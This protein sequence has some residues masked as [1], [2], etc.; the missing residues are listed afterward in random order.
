MALDY[1]HG[2]LQWTT[3]LTLND[4]SLQ[5]TGLSFQPK[6]IRFFWVGLQS[7]SDAVSEAVNERR[8][9]G[10]AT[11]TSNRRSIG[12]F[13][14]DTA[15]TSNCGSAARDDCCVCT[16]DGAG[17]SD[18]RLDLNAIA[19]DGF[20][21]IV[22]DVAPANITVFWEAWGGSDISV[23]VCGDIAEPAAGGNQD[24]TVTG[25]TP[26][27]G[28]DQIVML[29]GCQS[30]AALN[31]DSA[32]SS[33]FHVGFA[34]TSGNV[35]VCGTADDAS[36]AMDTD[37]Y[38]RTGECLSMIALAGAAVTEARATLTAWVADGFRLNWAERNATNRRSVFLA[39]K[40]G[41]WAVGAYTING[42]SGGATATVGSL[43]FAPKGVSLI[44]RMTAQDASD[45]ATAN[46]RIGMGCGSSTSSRRSMGILDEDATASSACEINTTLQYDQVLCFP[47]TAGA[48]QSAYDI[49]LMDADSFRIIVDTAGG[50]ASEWQGYLTFG[51]APLPPPQP[52]SMTTRVAIAIALAWIPTPNRPPPL[53]ELA[54]LEAPAVIVDEPPLRVVQPPAIIRSWQGRPGI[55]GTTAAQ[56][57]AVV[58]DE[59]PLRFV[60]PA[61][62]L[63]SWR[64]RP[65]QRGSTV[66][67]EEIAPV[68]DMPVV[69]QPWNAIL[70]WFRESPRRPRAP[71]FIP[72]S[73]DDPPLAGRPQAHIWASWKFR[74]RGRIGAQA[75][76]EP[77]AP[78][79]PP[80][81]R[82]LL[83]ARE[84][85]PVAPDVSLFLGPAISIP[86]DDV[87]PRLEVPA[88]VLLGW[89]PPHLRLPSLRKE[90]HWLFFL[91]DAPPLRV[92]QPPAVLL[93]W[94][95]PFR[96][97]PTLGELVQGVAPVV[98]SPPLRLVLPGSILD[99]WRPKYLRL[100]AN[101]VIPQGTVA[102]ADSPPLR[103]I[104]PAAV[105]HAWVPP[106]RPLPELGLQVIEPT[107]DAPPLTILGLQE[108]L[109]RAWRP[110]PPQ[111]QQR[112][113]LYPAFI[114]PDNPP[115][116]VRVPPHVLDAW[117]KANADAWPHLSGL[118]LPWMPE[119]RPPSPYA[120]FFQDESGPRY[121]FIDE[122]GA[123]Y[124]FGDDSETPG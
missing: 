19:S 12:T 4:T 1:A 70:S 124:F 98:D 26:G 52:R 116:M 60:L 97:P 115:G 37:G 117:R 92:P 32:E 114:P 109:I 57:D 79:N 120:L 46:D 86:G 78:D 22:D 99:A 69:A 100:P 71:L 48:L 10:F 82:H 93:S 40:G 38:C 73:S 68:T 103:L 51:D 122:T 59:P 55:R 85:Y 18:G 96:L 56:A 31:T 42:N 62:I 106:F 54:A 58:A 95:A 81:Q 121:V 105:L 64:G 89:R 102:V 16:T 75:E 43:P 63:Q 91:G 28:N 6:A 23:A 15:A 5:V 107:P 101:G 49:D 25:F 33:G 8:G 36:T 113:H 87:F 88:A 39:I 24:Y 94:R 61:S 77:P 90:P 3:A 67:R 7:A 35:T 50:V 34:N 11:S 45:V 123:A 74:D 76:A 44:G 83:P 65:G 30:S 41:Q 110:G 17:A 27:T 66:G 84:W 72:V 9:V 2:A 13:A 118:T 80:L 14:Q 112:R 47:S 53:P 21:M 108:R 104:L 111:P 119:G 29:A 20:T